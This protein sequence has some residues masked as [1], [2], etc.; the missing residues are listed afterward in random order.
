MI[1]HSTLHRQSQEIQ[2]SYSDTT[3]PISLPAATALICGLPFP[4]LASTSGPIPGT[5]H[6]AGGF[7]GNVLFGG[8]G[9]G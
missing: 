5:A 4:P 1:W 8:L 2:G 7:G 6:R 9:E 3:F